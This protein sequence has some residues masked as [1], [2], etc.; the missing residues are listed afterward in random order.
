MDPDVKRVLEM[1]FPGEEARY[2]NPMSIGNSPVSADEGAAAILDGIKT[3]T[4][5]PFWD[6][7]D[8][9]IPFAGALC[10][11]LDGRK[12]M[13]AII[14]TERVEIMPFGSTDES[15]AWFYGEGDRTLHWWRSKMRAFYRASAARNGTS[16]SDDT[17]LICE[18]FAV[19]RRL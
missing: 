11:L 14:E 19:L 5:S 16:F 6:W 17:P 12:R 4:S 9:R 8:G 7:P 10:V 13:R 15:F 18:W 3:S 1:A 2:F